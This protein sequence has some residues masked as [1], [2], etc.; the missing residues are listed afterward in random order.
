MLLMLE[1][2][3]FF[4]ALYFYMNVFFKLIRLQIAI[5]CTNLVLKRFQSHL[6]VVKLM[7]YAD[8][9]YLLFLVL[10]LTANDS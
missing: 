8:K 10:N 6:K 3:D 1:V 5:I 2:I 4:C 9:A 7:P